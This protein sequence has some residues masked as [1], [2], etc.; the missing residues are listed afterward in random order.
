MI[1]HDRILALSKFGKRD[2]IEEFVRDGLL[3]MNPLSYFVR[4]ENDGPRADRN[5]G[6][7]Y[8]IPG[9]GVTLSVKQEGKYVKIADLMGPICAS[10]EDDL[11]ANVFCMYAL[12]MSQT[13]SLI[14]SR[15]KEF[16]D[17]F[18]LLKDSDEFLRRVDAA[19]NQ[20]GFTLR[21]EIVKYID[22]KVYNGPMGIFKKNSEFS[23]QSE[24]RI[25]LVPGTGEPYSLKVG[26]LSDITV[27]GE[28]VRINE[29]LRVDYSLL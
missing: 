2:H 4:L 12:C 28:L 18:A 14:D 15:N 21:K 23:Y 19:A 9:K 11:K 7:G 10:H 6:L 13:Q 24:F 5:E 8:L 17:T 3:F 16:G 26:N 22:R 1:A 25:A 29:L 27:T 20:T